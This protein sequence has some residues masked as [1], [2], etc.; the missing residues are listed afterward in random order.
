MA[1]HCVPKQGMAR[2]GAASVTTWNSPMSLSRK[3]LQFPTGL[4]RIAT[5]LWYCSKLGLPPQESELNHTA[6]AEE[7][8][9][10]QAIWMVFSG[11]K[12]FVL[13][14]T[15]ECARML[16]EWRTHARQANLPGKHD[17]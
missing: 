2:I 9:D 14:L 5:K 4:W 11:V 1:T 7:S 3:V 6:R 10:L 15:A 16:V 12:L 13:A 17:G 8:S